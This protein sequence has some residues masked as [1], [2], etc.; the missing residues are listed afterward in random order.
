MVGNSTGVYKFDSI[1]RGHHIYKTVWTPLIDEMVWVMQDLDW[2]TIVCSM[3]CPHVR[4]QKVQSYGTRPQ[5]ARRAGTPAS[6][7]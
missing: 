7:I 2:D 1:A 4:A 5:P 3:L 6:L